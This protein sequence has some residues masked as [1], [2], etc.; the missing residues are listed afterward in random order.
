M[1]IIDYNVYLTLNNHL[2][3]LYDNGKKSELL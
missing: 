3:Y 1:T 2:T